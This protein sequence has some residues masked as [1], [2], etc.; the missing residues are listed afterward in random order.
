[1][2][3]LP[4]HGLAS[5][6]AAQAAGNGSVG[7]DPPGLTPGRLFGTGFLYGNGDTDLESTRTRR[8]GSDA[9][10]LHINAACDRN[11]ASAGDRNVAS[12]CDRNVASV[13]DRNVT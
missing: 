4:R 11:V 3:T 5:A 12:A 8:C 6:G 13:G 7:L 9:Q 1:M 10:L 2:S